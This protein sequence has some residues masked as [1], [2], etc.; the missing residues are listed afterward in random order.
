MSSA[1]LVLLIAVGVAIGTGCSKSSTASQFE[2]ETTVLGESAADSGTLTCQ[3][4]TC[5]FWNRQ[6]GQEIDGCGGTVDC[7]GCDQGSTCMGPFQGVCSRSCVA[8]TCADL[9]SGACGDFD[10]GCGGTL[11]C[12]GCAANEICTT[13]GGCYAPA[14]ANHSNIEWVRTIASPEWDDLRSVTIDAQ[15][16]IWTVGYDS[17]GRA[18][19]Q[20]ALSI[21]RFDSNGNL[22]STITHADMGHWSWINNDALA[23]TSSG[24]LFLHY[25]V[26]C[27]DH[28]C[29]YAKWGAQS[30]G[31]SLLIKLAQDGSFLWVAQEGDYANDLAIT[32][33]GTAW[34]TT[35]GF[36]GGSTLVRRSGS[37][38]LLPTPGVTDSYIGGLAVDGAGDVLFGADNGLELRDDSGAKMW[39]QRL[40]GT[41]WA[42]L[43]SVKIAPNGTIAATGKATGSLS[44]G[45]GSIIVPGQL[46]TVAL[47]TANA[48]GTPRALTSVRAPQSAKAVV[49]INDQ[50]I[51]LIHDGDM[52]SCSDGFVAKFDHD[53]QQ[54]WERRLS[55]DCSDQGQVIPEDVALLPDGSVIVVGSFLGTTS[56]G[57]AA[58]SRD[59]FILK[60]AP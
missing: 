58:G 5:A 16:D 47:L 42:T 24:D 31:N 52:Y 1:R 8:A 30:V 17:R 50:A 10:D 25:Y 20:E 40:T 38:Q 33:S 18:A 36:M 29:Q 28:A 35:G 13:S 53:L 44:W 41:G 3:P 19:G 14:G 60:L 51:A 4:K 43:N 21:L 39:K 59:G 2:P 15:G 22:K 54:I 34:T 9:G 32:P 48:D 49:A 27:T 26:N 46:N 12:G 11:N 6:C 56:V 7:G 45:G 55:P 23:I 57:T 37:G